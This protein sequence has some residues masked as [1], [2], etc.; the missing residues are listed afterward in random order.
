MKSTTK[1]VFQC[2]KVVS[3]I[4][5][6]SLVFTQKYPIATVVILAIGAAANEIINFTNKHTDYDPTSSPDA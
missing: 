2:I 3:G 5:G 6:T 1:L 4:V